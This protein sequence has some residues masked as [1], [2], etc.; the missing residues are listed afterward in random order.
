LEWIGKKKSITFQAMRQQNWFQRQGGECVL[1]VTIGGF[2]RRRCRKNPSWGLLNK[3]TSTGS[4]YSE[5]VHKSD[6][7]IGPISPAREMSMGERPHLFEHDSSLLT[8]QEYDVGMP[9]PLSLTSISRQIF[10][11]GAERLP[12][13]PFPCLPPTAIGSKS[14]TQTPTRAWPRARSKDSQTDSRLLNEELAS[15]TGISRIEVL[16]KHYFCEDGYK[17]VSCNQRGHVFLCK[18]RN[19]LEAYI[20]FKNGMLGTGQSDYSKSLTQYFN[21]CL[22]SFCAHDDIAN[23]IHE[24]DQCISEIRKI[25]IS[26]EYQ[27][28]RFTLSALVCESREKEDLLGAI[29]FQKEGIFFIMLE[30]TENDIL[31]PEVCGN[32][33]SPV[34]RRIWLAIQELDGLVK[35][36]DER[37]DK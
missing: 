8:A 12:Q 16:R 33:N 28:L 22:N 37:N 35:A 14:W 31:G 25:V 2:R 34:E 19:L 24:F 30:G 17:C 7:S 15:A 27:C 10:G 4:K 5:N 13:S 6:G 36:W 11:G 3:H 29:R 1:S 26:P 21:E 9:I 18:E 20:Q 23:H 32:Y